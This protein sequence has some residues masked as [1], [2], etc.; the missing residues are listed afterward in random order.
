MNVLSRKIFVA[1]AGPEWDEEI[2]SLDQLEYS[3][4]LIHSNVENGVG[5]MIGIVSKT[6]DLTDCG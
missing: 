1:S 4:P 3:L 5:Y 2:T 6:V